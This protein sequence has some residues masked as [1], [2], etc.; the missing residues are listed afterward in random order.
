MGTR[1]FGGQEI[2]IKTKSAQWC[3]KEK[4]KANQELF[5]FSD[6]SF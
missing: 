1:N 2:L 4:L 6:L 5:L 3:Y